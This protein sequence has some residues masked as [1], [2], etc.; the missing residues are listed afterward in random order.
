MIDI[1]E[2]D[3][4][5]IPAAST[6]RKTPIV[7]GWGF[8]SSDRAGSRMFWGQSRPQSCLRRVCMSKDPVNSA[9]GRQNMLR[10]PYRSIELNVSVSLL[11]PCRVKK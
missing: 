11:Q 10:N 8:F 4:G 6:N 7:P 5:S 3:Q 1:A 2:T 9:A